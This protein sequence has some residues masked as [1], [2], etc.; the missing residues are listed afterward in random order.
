M[1]T[2]TYYLKKISV[3]FEN[4]FLARMA[5]GVLIGVITGV[6]LFLGLQKDISDSVVLIASAFA[7]VF[8]EILIEILQKAIQTTQQLKPLNR[9]LGTI[10]TDDSWIYISA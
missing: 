1:K 10:S 8:A 4:N 3:L 6:L 5:F 9:V 7:G 2:I